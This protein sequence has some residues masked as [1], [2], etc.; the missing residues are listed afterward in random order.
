[1]TTSNAQ[2]EPVDA[3]V[4][5]R[6]GRVTTSVTKMNSPERASSIKCPIPSPHQSSQ[7][8]TVCNQ[9]IEYRTRLKAYSGTPGSGSLLDDGILSHGERDVAET[10]DRLAVPVSGYSLTVDGHSSAYVAVG[11]RSSSG[12]RRPN[13][14][15]Q[16]FGEDD[17]TGRHRSLTVAHEETRGDRN[18]CPANML[19]CDGGPSSPVP[20]ESQC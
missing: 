14:G 19:L 4:Q 9:D 15:N 16:F 12:C 20:I 11:V 18:G 3:A 10:V 17:V 6:N 7:Q 2:Q 13:A 5:L 1:M 8:G